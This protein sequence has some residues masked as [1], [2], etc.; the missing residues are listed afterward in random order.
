[1]MASAGTNIDIALDMAEGCVADVHIVPRRLPPIGALVAGRAAS[2]MLK[3]LPRLF[4]LCAAAHGVAAQ[5]AVDA[6][7]GLEVAPETRRRRVAAVLSERLVEQSRSAVTGLGLL[8][9]PSVATAM[10]DLIRASAAFAFSADAGVPERVGAIDLIER[11][12]D[13]IG[14]GGLNPID[15]D[16][17]A[18]FSPS[19]TGSLTARTDFEIIARL[20]RE[21]AHYASRPDIHGAVPETGPWARLRAGNPDSPIGR[22]PRRRDCRRGWMKSSLCRGCCVD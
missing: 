5:T 10:R 18:C 16:V 6:A 7:R 1:M 4:A 14:I 9:R 13:Q 17:S 22:R 20:A 8:E 19:G 11:A 3:L 12:L 21:G 2:E 15:H